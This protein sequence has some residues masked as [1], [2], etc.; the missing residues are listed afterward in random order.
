MP[1]FQ[2]LIIFLSLLTFNNCSECADEIIL[3]EACSKFTS[4]TNGEGC[5]YDGSNC[6]SGYTT[7]D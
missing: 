7:C 1:K 6:V 2:I 4:S 3:R 5:Y